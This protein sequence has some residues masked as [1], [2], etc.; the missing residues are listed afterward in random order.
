MGRGR[1]PGTGGRSLTTRVSPFYLEDALPDVDYSV[2]HFLDDD[3]VLGNNGILEATLCGA[4]PIEDESGFMG[5][6]DEIVAGHPV[7]PNC[8]DA[9]LELQKQS[10]YIESHFSQPFAWNQETGGWEIGRPRP[11]VSATPGTRLRLSQG[12]AED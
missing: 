9:A 10:I 11:A 1:R 8:V 3:N 12:L 2:V 4:Y 6:D 7:C 5:T